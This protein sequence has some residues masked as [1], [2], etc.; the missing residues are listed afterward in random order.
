MSIKVFRKRIRMQN[1]KNYSNTIRIYYF[2][3]LI[4]TSFG[5]IGYLEINMSQSYFI[6]RGKLLFIPNL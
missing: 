6:Q 2:T 1:S 3:P 5:M 4:F